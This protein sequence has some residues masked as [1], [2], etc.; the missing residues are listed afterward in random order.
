MTKPLPLTGVRVVDF[1]QY[2]AG[3]AVAMMLA[4]QGAEVIRVDPPGGP[5]WDSPANA[6]LNRGKL[7]IVLDL[8]T[9]GDRAIAL[10]LAASADVLVENFRPA[11]MARLGLGAEAV[12]ALNPRLVYLSLP[13]FSAGDGERTHLQAWEGVIAAAVGQFTDMGLNRILMGINPSF[14]PL[15]LAS[16]YAAVFGAMAVTFALFARARHGRGE[17]VEVPPTTPP[18]WRTCRI[19][20]SP[21]ASA[22]SSGA[23]RPAW[24]WT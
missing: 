20:T 16:A 10:R 5:M 13:G 17:V 4:D 19:A 7:S 9:E 24:P 18:P 6:V 2:V 22:R 15:P 3:P 21:C 14:S 12:T 1:G 11:V 23:G 8:K